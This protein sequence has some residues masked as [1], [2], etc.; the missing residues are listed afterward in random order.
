[1][2]TTSNGNPVGRILQPQS[3][4]ITYTVASAHDAYCTVVLEGPASITI[5]AAVIP[6]FSLGIGN[7]CTGATAA[8]S[9][10]AAPP[11][12][13]QVTWYAQNATI[14]SGQGTRS[15]QYKAGDVGP[16]LLGCILTFPD[17]RCPTSHRQV[18]SVNG[19][20]DATISLAKT[21]IHAGETVL[22][23]YT[24]NSNVWTW[25]LDN[26][27]REAIVGVGGCGANNSPCHALYMSTHAGKSTITLHVTGFCPT[28]K[29]V[30]IDLNVLP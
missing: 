16:M 7:I 6:D 19:D 10:I 5:P 18:V 17:S 11:P 15:I 27:L 9:L 22:I 2:S 29:D 28:T 24:M 23:T 1:V 12:D 8:A 3:T 26:S 30:S 4:A 25:N 20:P 21:E 13:A 14:V